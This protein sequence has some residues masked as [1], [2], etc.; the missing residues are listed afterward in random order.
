[1]DK[2]NLFTPSQARR[3]DKYHYRKTRLAASKIGISKPEVV[4]KSRVTYVE[5]VKEKA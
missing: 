4:A 2:N 3:L 1:M 5:R